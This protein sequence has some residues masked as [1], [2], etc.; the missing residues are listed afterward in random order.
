VHIN[1]I[2]GDCPGKTELD[3]SLLL[4]GDVFVEYEPQT[5]LE[6]DIQQ[7]EIA[8][9]VTEFHQVIRGLA[10]GRT[11]V[12]QLTIF[13]GVGFAIEDFSALRYVKDLMQQ[14]PTNN[15]WIY[16]LIPKIHVI[17][18]ACWRIVKKILFGAG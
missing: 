10:T 7:L 14:S 11:G 4:R 6:G 3:K 1:A 5:R 2:S 13:D 17:Y 12:R 8:S 18:L 15:S 9:P 16:W